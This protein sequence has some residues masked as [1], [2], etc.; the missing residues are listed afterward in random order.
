MPKDNIERAIAKGSGTG[1][2]GDSFEEITYEG[3]GPGGWF[4]E[5]L[6]RL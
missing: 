4:C 6:K 2:G 5:I 3:I 1:A